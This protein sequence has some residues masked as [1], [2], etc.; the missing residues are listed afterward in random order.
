[1]DAAAELGRST[2]SKHRFNVSIENEQ[3]DTRRDSQTCPAKPSFQ[4]RTGARKI[5]PV[6]LTMNRIGN[7]T[8]LICTL[9]YVM[10]TDAYA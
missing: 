2:M 8:Q 10:T 6:Q 4:A 3:A 7:L 9:L 1:M 5:F